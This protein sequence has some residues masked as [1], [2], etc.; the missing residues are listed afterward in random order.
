[1]ENPEDLS[2]LTDPMFTLKG[3]KGLV[4]IDEIQRCPE[5]FPVLRVLADR[6][7]GSARFLVL[8]SASPELLRQSSESLA[9]RIMYHELGGFSLEEVGMNNHR[10]LWIRGRVSTVLPGCH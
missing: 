6:P 7:K 10:R 3:L 5:L 9:G 2:R 4:V 8:G 1:M